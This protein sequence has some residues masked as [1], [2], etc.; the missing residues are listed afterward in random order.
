MRPRVS[1]QLRRRAARCEDAVRFHIKVRMRWTVKGGKWDAAGLSSVCL[2]RPPLPHLSLSIAVLKLIP[3]Y[4]AFS[5]QP[6][7]DGGESFMQ[8]CCVLFIPSS[9][10]SSSHFPLSSP[11]RLWS[12]LSS[13][14]GRLLV[15]KNGSTRLLAARESSDN[16]SLLGAKKKEEK[17]EPRFWCVKTEVCVSCLQVASFTAIYSISSQTF[18]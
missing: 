8:H 12:G 6:P 1:S 14:T 18:H 11:L 16:A 5:Y 4:S 2:C 3:A 10:S 15:T 9:S 7:S 13:S 17:A